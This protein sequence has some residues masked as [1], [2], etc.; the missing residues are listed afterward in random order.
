[1]DEDV[2]K[3]A[4]YSAMLTVRGAR[5]LDLDVDESIEYLFSEVGDL[6][7]KKDHRFEA[8]KTESEAEAARLDA[9]AWSNPLLA[10][11]PRFNTPFSIYCIVS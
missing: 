5:N 10:P 4:S 7:W 9:A 6:Y 1:M 2:N 3:A 8:A 11:L